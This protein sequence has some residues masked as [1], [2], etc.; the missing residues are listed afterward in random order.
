ME[1]QR[2]MW[3][4][5]GLCPPPGEEEDVWSTEEEDDD[6]YEGGG[7]PLPDDWVPEDDGIDWDPPP[8]QTGKFNLLKTFMTT[9]WIIQHLQHK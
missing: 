2:W 3:D 4:L 6:E 1:C 9:C 8:P 5:R 7:I